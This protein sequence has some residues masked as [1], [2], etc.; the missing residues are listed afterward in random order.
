MF[1][2]KKCSNINNEDVNITTIEDPI[3]I[4]L[5]GINQIQVNPK[6][7]ITFA[8]C[9]RAILRQDPDIILVGEIRDL[10]TASIAICC[11]LPL[12]SSM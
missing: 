6:T 10:E 11:C 1:N 7:D 8:N 2:N 9:L 3:E 12:C 5:E 4:R